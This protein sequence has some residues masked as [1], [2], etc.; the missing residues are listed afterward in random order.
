MGGREPGGGA[1]RVRVELARDLDAA[2]WAQ[3]HAADVVPDAAPY[4][5]DRMA[6]HGVEAVFR[7]PLRGRALPRVAGKVRDRAAGVELVP[8]LV[9]R[10]RRGGDAGVDAVL[11]MDE[12]TGVA[13]ALLG[14]R[15]TPVLTG[16]AWLDDPADLTPRYRAAVRRALPRTAGVWTNVA[17]MVPR[18]VAAWGLPADEVH[19]LPL[20]IDADFFPAQPWPDGTGL[21]VSAGEDRMRDHATLVDAVRRVRS[22]HPQT[23]LEI[24]T[25]LPLAA[26]PD[27]A[28][29]HRERMNGR[30]RD[31]Y[32]RATVVAV[33]LHPTPL[34]SGLT[35]V[36]EALASARPVVVTDN[37]GVDEYVQH[38]VTG[39]LVPPGDPAALADALAGLLADPERAREMGRRG[40]AAVESCWTTEHMAAGL[41]DLVRATVRRG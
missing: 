23:H 25:S 2:D 7:A 27:L 22:R 3:R 32:R 5:L 13:A 38:G 34:G 9:D 31:L 10:V 1:L 39:L 33:A 29:V 36:L 8:A 26:G 20:G 40:R 12:R 15:G 19:H 28:T 30:M 18:L 35:V 14:G 17:P 16:I 6:A 24:A 11:C 4:G 41:A 21:V 37:P